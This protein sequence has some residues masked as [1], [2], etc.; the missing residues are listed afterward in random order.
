MTLAQIYWN[1][2]ME[3]MTGYTAKEALGRPMV[4]VFGFFKN[5]YVRRSHFL[6]I[7][8][9]PKVK[10]CV[11]L[12]AHGCRHL[13]MAGRRHEAMG[14]RRVADATTPRKKIFIW[15]TRGLSCD[16]LA[17]MFRLL[18]NQAYKRGVQ[19]RLHHAAEGRTNGK[20]PR[21]HVVASRPKDG[22]GSQHALH[23]HELPPFRASNC[24]GN[25][26]MGDLPGGK[27]VRSAI[28]T[29]YR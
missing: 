14:L 21:L 27:V 10:G 9:T 12:C 11:V 1:H 19:A 7:K 3:L 18:C 26:L 25:G 20:R 13:S 28:H 5:D 22:Q 29:R 15:P 24:Q 8:N 17:N 16:A 23:V 4:E 6:F 2:V